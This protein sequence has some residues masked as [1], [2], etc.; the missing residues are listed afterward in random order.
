MNEEFNNEV[1]IEPGLSNKIKI[2]S[3]NLLPKLCS[4]YCDRVS[5]IFRTLGCT[6]QLGRPLR[7]IPVWKWAV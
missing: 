4:R 2:K 5:G 7:N 6:N 3:Q 1:R